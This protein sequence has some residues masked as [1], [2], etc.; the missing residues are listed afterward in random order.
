MSQIV[1]IAVGIMSM[2]QWVHLSLRMSQRRNAVDD[3]LVFQ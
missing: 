1:H 3:M 2:L